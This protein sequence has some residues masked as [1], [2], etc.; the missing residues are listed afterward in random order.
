MVER[1]DEIEALDALIA[2]VMNDAAF[3]MALLTG[4]AGIGKSR[5]AR[6]AA[7][8][9]R[10][11]GFDTLTGR[12][13]QR[14]R[15][16]PFAPF[17]DVLRQRIASTRE[18]PATLL[19]PQASRLAALLPEYGHLLPRDDAVAAGSPEQGKRWLFED[20][21]TLLRR[22]AERQPLLLL[23][24][25]L[26]WADPT[27]L[28]LLELLPRR[29][30]TSPLVLLGTCRANEAGREVTQTLLNLQRERVP[31]HLPLDP[32]SERGVARIAEAM[33]PAP[34]PHHLITTVHSRTGGNPFMIE[35]MV[36]LAAATGPLPPAG[37]MVPATVREIVYQRIDGL[38]STTLHLANLAAIAGERVSIDVLQTISEMEQES[39]F[40]SLR[41]LVARGILIETR[42]QGVPAIAFRHD[43]TR[44]ALLERLLLTERRVLHRTVAD[45]LETITGQTSIP[46]IAG[47]LGYH[48]HVAEEWEKALTYS[49]RAGESAWEVRAS[50]EA[51]AHFRR[52][53]D[54]AIALGD[55]RQAYLHCRCGQALALLGAYDDATAHLETALRE[56]RGQSD[57]S[58]ELEVQYAL[59]GHFAS[60]DYTTARS[61]AEQG[62][63][64]ARARHDPVWEARML[65]RLG[66][67]LTNLTLFP[68]GR[69]LHEAALEIIDGLGKRWGIA[70]TLDHIGMSHYLSGKIPDARTSFERAAAIFRDTG[71]Y[72]RAASALTSR[73]LYHAVLDGAC[74]TDTTPESCR[75]DVEEGLRLSREIGWR[76]GEAYAL[77]AVAT[78]DLAEARYRD[79]LHHG[80]T[81]LAVAREIDHPQ[82]SVIALYMLG[83]LQAS[84]LDDEAAL[85]LFVE[86]RELAQAIGSRQWEERLNAWV[87][88][89]ELRLEGAPLPDATMT[90]WAVPET[91]GQRRSM[92]TAIES[93]ID[94]GRPEQA[95][96]LTHLLL[97]ADAV[98]QAAEPV[99]LRA[100]ALAALDRRE[101]AEAAYLE[102]RR[103]ATETGP[104]GLL[105]RIA[106][107]RSRLWRGTDLAEAEAGVAHQLVT[108]I[109][110]ELPDGSGRA[111]LHAS[112]VSRLSG[113][114]CQQAIAAAPGHLSAREIEVLRHLTAGRTDAE[115]AEALFVSRRTVGTHVRHIYDKLGVSSRAEAAAWAVRNNIA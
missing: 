9:C 77:V 83:L 72:E 5:L 101:E 96:Q 93:L 64:L 26:H 24:E 80:G 84:I 25:D 23:L 32:I 115:I 70:D 81:G 112:G 49:L 73:G 111:F 109:A 65:N 102:A 95:V 1:E 106:A 36:A 29:L 94:T 59:A 98:S 7:S 86:A 88:R 63:S 22:L 99:L 35:E 114:V 37:T 55:P 33:L 44:D 60:H 21:A 48:F 31:L 13:A 43:L 47:N 30:D 2:S 27:T 107:G 78:I 66:N 87:S 69:E 79:A 38:D 61:H 100:E 34:P 58:I 20:I 41:A 40:A 54:A 82:W 3:R 17:V 19:G 18:D 85:Q 11:L 53:L 57:T 76:A 108:S 51:L 28:E 92:L 46:G 15:D 67:V 56:A 89:C 14:D 50:A 71:D 16:F 113:P 103:I 45:A 105:W 52:A 12:C 8:R 90:T 68:E 74:P 6:E 110:S 62:L 4:E 97:P 42:S 104:R 75:P 91:I 10:A 39:F